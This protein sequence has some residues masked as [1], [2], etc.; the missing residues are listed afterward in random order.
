MIYNSGYTANLGLISALGTKETTFLYDLEIHASV[1][2]GMKLSEA[3]R[4]PFR[5]NDLIS[6]EKRL[7]H[8][9]PPTFVLIESLYSI[10]GDLAPILE[11]LDL[12]KEYGAELIVDEAHA[13][14]IFG[15]QGAG[16]VEELHV[17]HSLFARVH[18][19]SK[20]LGTHGASV[21]G[22]TQLIHYL[23][24]FSRP[25]IYT[26]AL[27]PAS[28]VDIANSYE[29]LAREA[30][31][32]QSRLKSLIQHFYQTMGSAFSLNHSSS[33]CTPIHPIYFE[34]TQELR[35][36]A[37]NCRLHGLDVRP[38]FPPT[39]PKGKE[40]LRVVLHSFNHEQEIDQL[41]EILCSG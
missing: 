32:H 16:L 20:A 30:A 25:F 38:I 39:V 31:L 23:I 7:R 24:N 6:L 11:I 4:I 19:F 34:S 1:I 12:C 40:C 2:D 27:P 28:F 13:T 14:G 5:H 41:L 21:L 3:K 18:T 8:A 29:R 15:S 22:S 10:S 36:A 37:E 9:S 26:T 35:S 33:I 17:E